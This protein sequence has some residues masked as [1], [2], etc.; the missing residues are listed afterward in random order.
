MLNSVIYLKIHTH[1]PIML[2]EKLM[3]QLTNSFIYVISTAFSK[4]GCGISFGKIFLV[5]LCLKSTMVTSSDKNHQ[6]H[7]FRTKASST[8]DLSSVF[9]PSYESY[10]V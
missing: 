5:F 9:P 8:L 7:D 2:N 6:S 4:P 1:T 3:T 10:T